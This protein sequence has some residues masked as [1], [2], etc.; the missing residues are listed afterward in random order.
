MVG[1]TRIYISRLQP[2]VYIDGKADVLVPQ[3]RL[4]RV[5]AAAFEQLLS[6]Q[7]PGPE[8]DAG[9]RSISEKVM[10]GQL[11]VKISKNVYGKTFPRA[12]SV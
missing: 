5:H 7:D 4:Q 11:G 10:G 9:V 3:H 12:S 8:A 1:R 2:A 6:L